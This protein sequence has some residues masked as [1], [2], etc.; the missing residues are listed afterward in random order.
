MQ[1]S[2]VAIVIDQVMKF[3]QHQNRMEDK[4]YLTEGW[5]SLLQQ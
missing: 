3:P 1:K 2:L 4:D 5:N